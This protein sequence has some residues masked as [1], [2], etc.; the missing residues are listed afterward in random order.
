MRKG[1]LAGC[2]TVVL[3]LYAAGGCG[4]SD[5]PVLSAGA[6]DGGP[7]GSSDG[8]AL[9][10]G[11]GP[12]SETRDQY[13]AG[14]G[15]PVL[16]D[17]TDAG[18]TAT[19]AGQLAQVAFRYALCTCS[20]Y[21][22]DHALATD[23]F[24]SSK[25]PYD[26]MH[27][28]P[29]GSVGT[30]GNLNATAAMN[31]GGSL[32]ASD[33]TGLTTNASLVALGELHVQG[34]AHTGPKLQVGTDA[35]LAGGLQTSG[36]VAIAGTLHVPA[37]APLDVGGQ[38]QIGSVAQGA[39][40]VPPACDCAPTDL[41]D[42]AGF[43][44]TYRGANDDAAAGIDPAMLENVTAPLS[45]MLP[46]GRIF[47]TRVGG[48]API[49]LTAQGRVAVFV[50][51]DLSTT[52]DFALDVPPG[53]EVDLFV[54]GGVTVGG[55]FQVGEAANPARARTYVG[56]TGTVN[57]QGA[58]QLAGNLYSPRA[59]VVLGGSA[60]TVLYGSIFAARLSASA[61]LTIHFD[62]AILSQA[63]GSSCEPPT[64]CSSC[65]E[66]GGQACDSGTC[67]GCTDSSQCCAPLVCRGGSCVGNI[68]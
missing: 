22:S 64:T 45:A 31:I 10:D 14:S 20:G 19:C 4:S 28:L 32:W 55:A 21:V 23:A 56:G 47:F 34:E 67:G 6:D 50:G 1:A 58:A 59:E 44:E 41:V 2:A 27:P 37:G 26:P 62:E 49:H 63:Q 16:V 42:I 25:G 43:V 24:D 40:T 39:V 30:N 65:R 51:G 60:P 68:Q 57:L 3:C 17:Q 38:K 11:L 5:V 46:C 52:S 54:E 29:G 66:C 12:D 35:W 7:G 18:V 61:D 8:N 9:L 13:C 33:A 36:D 48:N 15:P 53:S